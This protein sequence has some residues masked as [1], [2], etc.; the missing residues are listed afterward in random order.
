MPHRDTTGTEKS[1]KRGHCVWVTQRN[2]VPRVSKSPA[3]SVFALKGFCTP[4]G[5]DPNLCM[6]FSSHHSTITTQLPQEAKQRKG[7]R[8]LPLWKVQEDESE[9]LRSCAFQEDFK[10]RVLF[11]KI[12]KKTNKKKTS[13]VHWKHYRTCRMWCVN[14]KQFCCF[15]EWFFFKPTILTL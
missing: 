9:I 3:V 7:H 13:R 10:I 14:R 12:V 5:L 4:I 6:A 15:R 11:V 1:P 8:W 2:Q